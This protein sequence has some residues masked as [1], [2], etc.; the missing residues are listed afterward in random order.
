MENAMLVARSESVARQQ[1][2]GVQGR[3]EV[4]LQT[5]L[6]GVTLKKTSVFRYDVR[7]LGLMVRSARTIE[8]SRTSADDITLRDRR[9][10]CR[11]AFD[12]V[13]SKYENTVFGCRE[14]LWYDCQAI[15]F[16]GFMLDISA[17]DKKELILTNTD[18]EGSPYSERYQTIIIQLSQC[19]RNFI[20]H[21]GE[22]EQKVPT[23][24]NE[25]N[26]QKQF[27]EIITSQY[28]LT[29]P[30][31]FLTLGP[32]TSYLMNPMKHGMRTEDCPDLGEGKYLAIGAKKTIR[33]IEGPEGRGA[34]RTAMAVDVKKTSFHH[35]NRVL[36]KARIILGREVKANDAAHLVQ[37]LKGI[38][39]VT[40]HRRHPS[41]GC[42]ANVVSE[43]P[44]QKKFRNAAGVEQ[45]IVEYFLD[46]YDLTLQYPDTPLIVTHLGKNLAYLPMELVYVLDG[47]RVR[48]SQQTRTEVQRTIAASSAPAV[49][50]RQIKQ[51]VNA[52]NLTSTN[53][54]HASAGVEIT[55]EPLVARGRLLHNPTI[56]YGDSA[57][58]VPD[59]AARWD[60]HRK[61]YINPAKVTKWSVV[62]ISNG[63]SKDVLSEPMLKQF[64]QSL[65]S[66]ARSRGMEVHEPRSL[67]YISPVCQ[68]I[69]DVFTVAASSALGFLFF[70]T[71]ND[72]TTVHCHLKRL[73]REHEIV[74]Q[75]LMMNTAL[76]IVCHS[77]K[78]TLE[79][80]VNKFNMKNGGLNYTLHMP[81]I[82]G[83]QDL[84]PN[85]RMVIGIATS[86][87]NMCHRRDR[88]RS[89]A[90][91]I[92]AVI[93]VA[94][95]IK[96]D[97]GDFVGDCLFQ[98]A[99]RDNKIVVL[100][101]V[102][103]TFVKAFMEKRGCPP[104][105]IVI[106]RN[107]SVEGQFYDTLELEL[108]M[109]RTV[110][111]SLGIQPG[112]TLIATQKMH[113]VRLMPRNI[114]ARDK[115]SAQNVKPGTAVDQYA[116]HPAFKEFY[117]NSHV[118]LQGTARV[119]RYT[120]LQDDANMSMDEV[121]HLTYGLSFGHQI[122]NSATSMPT[123]V[124]VAG[125]YAER[126]LA[127]FGATLRDFS[128]QP[129]NG[130]TSG[131][132]QSNMSADTLDYNDLANS[133]SYANCRLKDTRINA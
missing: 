43:T 56:E 50:A 15:L 55:S 113:N 101:P 53:K 47:Q 34:Q 110:T 2:P 119:P 85:D 103:R 46:R 7:V 42:I 36:E 130:S 116:T 17:T 60:S 102:I 87:E 32:A 9:V 94:A 38:S 108:M 33:Y 96:S 62:V 27:L 35:E 12:A 57:S 82:S 70:I 115:P 76:E 111:Q 8:L 18:I 66:E 90:D 122:V 75:D 78:H 48:P 14:T 128:G 124:M 68:E 105:D 84:L 118:A 39:V 24:P 127:M 77:K 79:N 26:S 83:S 69:S 132:P 72:I 1:K 37:G 129:N 41:Y 4:S 112:V 19:E 74:T 104:K 30:D 81:R 95:N 51:L 91:Q 21:G 71:A 52:F 44:R 29:N 22:T 28:A 80:I 109:I 11:Y 73:E 121:E 6:Y 67:L 93:G 120:V 20:I 114:D 45:S 126:G 92:P 3:G 65:I 49:R 99:R 64:V 89:T 25:D 100:Q 5:N 13:C 58:V 131:S 63:R 61:L 98:K 54:A 16:T 125:C 59:A 106:Y 117:L 88:S 107:G 123:P 97:P 31:D 133:L 23:S 40:R 10:I 86:M